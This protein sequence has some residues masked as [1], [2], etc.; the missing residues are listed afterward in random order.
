MQ[1]KLVPRLQ[2]VD[3]SDFPIHVDAQE[4]LSRMLSEEL[5]KALDKELLEGFFQMNFEENV[6]LIESM[7]PGQN[8]YDAI[9]G[10]GLGDVDLKMELSLREKIR[11]ARM[12][13]IKNP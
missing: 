8:P 9:R 6:A 10:I 1:T 7:Y 3:I 13:S 11:A 2:R 5:A 12:N 4:E